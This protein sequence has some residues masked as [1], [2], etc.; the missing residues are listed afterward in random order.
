MGNDQSRTKGAPGDAEPGPVDYY[1]L[2]QVDE[3]ATYDEIKVVWHAGPLANCH[4][5]RIE[6]LL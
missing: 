2:L 5:G 1:E 4:S 3:E 6:S